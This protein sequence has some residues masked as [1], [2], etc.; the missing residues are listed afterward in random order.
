RDGAGMAA[1]P[2]RAR[3][4]ARPP[5]SRG[6]VRF[7]NRSQH[8]QKNACHPVPPR[9]TDSAEEAGRGGVSRVRHFGRLAGFFPSGGS[10][11]FR[12]EE[13]LPEEG[14]EPAAKSIYARQISKG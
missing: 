6:K 2:W 9:A 13:A 3:A 4:G 5:V 8:L 7:D 10:Q 11:A 12:L 1:C 14:C